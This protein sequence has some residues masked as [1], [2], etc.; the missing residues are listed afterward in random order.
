MNDKFK[1]RFWNKK[2]CT[3][4]KSNKL[5]YNDGTYTQVGTKQMNNGL[6]HSY[7]VNEYKP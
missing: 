3:Y 7:I 1:F 4:V 6:Y 5:I 2:T